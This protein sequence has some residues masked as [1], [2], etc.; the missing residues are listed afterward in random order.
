[1]AMNY[2]IDDEDTL[3][4]DIEEIMSDNT[5]SKSE[6]LIASRKCKLERMDNEYKLAII[7]LSQRVD[8]PRCRAKKGQVCR[9]TVQGKFIVPAHKVRLKLLQFSSK[10]VYDNLHYAM[11]SRYWKEC[12]WNKVVKEMTEYRESGQQQRDD[13][14]FVAMLENDEDYDESIY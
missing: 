10:K 12:D 3:D 13:D 8:C 6:K 4:E 11:N 9:G 5:L 2:R 1:M 14:E 7:Y